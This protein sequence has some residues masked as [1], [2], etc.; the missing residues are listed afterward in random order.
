MRIALFRELPLDFPGGVTHVMTLLIDHLKQHG[1]DVLLFAP[2]ATVADYHGATVRSVPSFYLPALKRTKFKIA[3]P[4]P[5]FVEQELADFG[6]DIAHVLHPMTLGL[7]GIYCAQTLKIPIVA[8]YHTQYHIYLDYYKLKLFKPLLW[9][10]TRWLFNKADIAL[11]PSRSVADMMEA[12]G[13]HT[14]DIWSRG[15]DAELFSPAHRSTQWRKQFIKNDNEKIILYVGRLYKEKN[16]R[17]I[18][19]AIKNIEHAQ[20]VF[21]GDGPE[22]EFLQHAIPSGKAHF[23]GR[24]TGRDLSVA[25]SSAD[26]FLFPSL[27]EGCPNSVMEAVSSGLP[28]I[29]VNGYGVC[30]IVRDGQCGYL[31]EH[32]NESTIIEII[33]TL[34]TDEQHRQQLSH[35]ARAY[36]L[37]R[38]WPVIMQ[39]LMDHYTALVQRN[40]QAQLPLMN[41]TEATAG[42]RDESYL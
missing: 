40:K 12:G 24:L 31:Y 2:D 34:L 42:L 32:G 27:T 16:I 35:R 26:L 18:I 6:A 20:F 11:S 41:E 37:S 21:V 5:S 22:R 19:T 33:N 30:D 39:P 1:H 17:R 7:V 29:G 14:V 13:I 3:L 10:Y 36:A 38:S 15:V 9:R 23:T 28:V 4:S 8:S 25:Y